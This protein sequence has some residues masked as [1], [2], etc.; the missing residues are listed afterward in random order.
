V[1]RIVNEETGE[2]L[3]DPVARVL[4]EGCAVELANHAAL[5]TRDGRT[6][7]GRSKCFAARNPGQN[8]RRCNQRTGRR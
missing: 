3:E 4:R 8:T 5:A 7:P 6:V 1:F 2:P